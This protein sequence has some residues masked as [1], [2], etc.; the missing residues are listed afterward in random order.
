M[1]PSIVRGN[2]NAAVIAIAEKAADILLGKS[3]NQAETD[4]R[5]KSDKQNQIRVQST[6]GRR[7]VRASTGQSASS[8]HDDQAPITHIKH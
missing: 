1:I 8:A 2:T 6:R 3:A 5:S 7:T 4:P